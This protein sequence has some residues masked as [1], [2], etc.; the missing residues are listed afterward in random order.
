LRYYKPRQL[1]IKLVRKHANS[2]PLLSIYNSGINIIVKGSKFK[3]SHILENT[4][5][6]NKVERMP[7][8]LVLFRLSNSGLALFYAYF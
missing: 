3:E 6:W 5:L 7:W 8:L 1:F 2:I 4:K